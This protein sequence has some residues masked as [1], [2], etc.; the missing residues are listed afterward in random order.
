MDIQASRSS[1]PDNKLATAILCGGEIA[2]LTDMVFDAV[3]GSLLAVLD[4]LEITTTRT[5]AE[6]ITV[7]DPTGVAI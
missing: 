4:C 5:T 1:N 7:C 3:K 6:E 2:A